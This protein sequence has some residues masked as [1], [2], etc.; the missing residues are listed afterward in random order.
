M[1]VAGFAESTRGRGWLVRSYS[2]MPTDE[3][4]LREWSAGDEAAGN[5]LVRRHF[6]AVYGFFR[7]KLSDDVDDLIQRTFLGALEAAGRYR[8]EAGFRAFV[9]GIA[10]N[11]LLEHFRSLHRGRSVDPYASSALDLDPS[12]SEMVARFEEQRLLLMALRAI[13]LDDQI[14][15]ELRYWEQLSTEQ[16]GVVLGLTG[17]SARSR[18]KRA[19]ARVC[20]KLAELTDDAARLL[21]TTDDLERWARSLRAVVAA[22][23]AGRA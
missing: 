5:D 21:S 2:P 14:A 3:E 12:P 15:L 7:S 8:G 20:D 18:L 19:R 23:R 6:D 11:I 13:P 9:F 16:I 1:Q 22:D 10:R 17:G 4:L